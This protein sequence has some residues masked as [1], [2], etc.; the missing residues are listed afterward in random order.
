ML[1][2]AA[3]WILL[4]LGWKSV[5]SQLR[6]G[7]TAVDEGA[8]AVR[9]VNGS[10]RTAL[11]SSNSVRKAARIAAAEWIKRLMDYLKQVKGW[12]AIHE[13]NNTGERTRLGSAQAR[14]PP[15]YSRW[16]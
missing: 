1:Y 10:A 12:A 14:Y 3:D 13:H 2:S 11:A 7:L 9:A 4:D 6:S 5:T 8:C 15:V 16:F